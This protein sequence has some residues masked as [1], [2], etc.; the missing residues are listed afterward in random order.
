MTRTKMSLGASNMILLFIGTFLLFQIVSAITEQETQ[1]CDA[2]WRNN[3]GLS[4]VRGGVLNASR[5]CDELKLDLVSIVCSS[6]KSSIVQMFA[7][8]FKLFF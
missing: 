4:A 2:L 6:D 3:L 7:N 5:C 8:L 1:A